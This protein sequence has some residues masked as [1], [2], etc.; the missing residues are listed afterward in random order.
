[1]VRGPAGVSS[2]GG[3]PLVRATSISIKPQFP[4]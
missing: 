3:L 1:M 2:T 4:E